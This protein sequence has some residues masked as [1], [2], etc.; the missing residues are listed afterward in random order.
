LSSLISPLESLVYLAR[1]KGDRY[2]ALH[3]MERLLSVRAIVFGEDELGAAGIHASMGA[4]L[5]EKGEH[6]EAARSLAHAAEIR[7]KHNMDEDLARYVFWAALKWSTWFPIASALNSF[8]ASAS[9]ICANRENW[10]LCQRVHSGLSHNNQQA[11]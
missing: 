1:R 11:S 7:K 2:L 4:L 10:H 9:R 8:A 3:M 5:E 6:E